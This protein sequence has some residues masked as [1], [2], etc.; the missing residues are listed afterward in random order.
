MCV[1]HMLHKDKVQLLKDMCHYFEMNSILFLLLKVRKLDIEL[2]VQ[3]NV[4][5]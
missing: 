5:F 3:G 4:M 2:C 1:F